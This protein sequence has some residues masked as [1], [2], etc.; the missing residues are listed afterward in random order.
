MTDP[1]QVLENA[2]Q[3]QIKGRSETGSEQILNS[4][5]SDL[6]QCIMEITDILD[7]YVHLVLASVGILI[8]A[9]AIVT[10]LRQSRCATIFHKLMISL[11][12]Y[13]L[14]YCAF[15]VN[16]RCLSYFSEYYDCKWNNARGLSAIRVS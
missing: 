10:L 13:D 16:I 11:V 6:K 7:S 12:A 9:F 4:T 8:N 15:S 3:V 5:F 14:V 2:N 1:K